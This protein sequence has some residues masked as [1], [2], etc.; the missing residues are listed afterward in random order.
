MVESSYSQDTSV[1]YIPL[2][3]HGYSK[4]KMEFDQRDVKECQ[5]EDIFRSSALP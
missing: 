4:H 2:V 5:L 1:R 3:S